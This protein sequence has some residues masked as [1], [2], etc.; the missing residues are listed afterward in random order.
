MHRNDKK[1]NLMYLMVTKWILLFVSVLVYTQQFRASPRTA[2][3]QQ[4]IA[5]E[6]GSPIQ[7][8]TGPMMLD[9]SDRTGTGI[10]TWPRP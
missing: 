6:W 3:L 1:A 10:S 9:F 4:P 2:L 5:L 8:L 7:L